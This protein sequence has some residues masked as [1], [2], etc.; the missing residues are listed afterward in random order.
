[1]GHIGIIKQKIARSGTFS[2]Q[3]RTA[4]SAERVV[5]DALAFAGAGAFALVIECVPERLGEIITRSLPIPT[6]GIG[7]GPGCDG[8]A[9]VTQDM[10]GLFKGLSPRFLK[11]Y[12][13]LSQIIVQSLTQFRIEVEQGVYPTADHTYSI[14]DEELEALVSRLTT[15]DR[16]RS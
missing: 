8:Q 7:A 4:S 6:I 11:V 3:G 13:D 2:I 9:L 15:S 5:A 10:L 1:M 12:L 14:S 16:P